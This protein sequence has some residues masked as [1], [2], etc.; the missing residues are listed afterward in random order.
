M[1]TTMLVLAALIAIALLHAPTADVGRSSR[2]RRP[3]GTRAPGVTLMPTA[4][5]PTR[6]AGRNRRTPL[7]EA[8]WSRRIRVARW[9]G[10]LE[11]RLPRSARLA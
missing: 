5:S 7:V 4:S 6:A 8:L 1:K 2:V 9:T 10:E 11:G 3:T